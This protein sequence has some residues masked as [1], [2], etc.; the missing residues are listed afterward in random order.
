MS[1]PLQRVFLLAAALAL[2][3]CSSLAPDK[4]VRATQYDFGPQAASAPGNAPA[5]SPL[6]LDDVDPS[7]SL[8][9]SAI[10]YRLA[11][12]D[13]HQLRPY[14]LARWTA[15]PAQL[16]RQRLRARRRGPLISIS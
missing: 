8:D 11:Y 4:P 15:P 14:A 16:I 2:A 5:G 6:V 12:A 3:G 1:A 13:A 9:T 10:L 7:G